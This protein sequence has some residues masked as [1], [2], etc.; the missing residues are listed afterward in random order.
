LRT[1]LSKD[2][3]GENLRRRVIPILQNEEAVRFW[4]EDF[5]SYHPSALDPVLNKL[6]KFLLNDR[7]ARILRQ[8]KNKLDFRRIMDSS[9]IL[10]MH[11]PAGILGSDS[12]NLIG[13]LSLALFYHAAMSRANIP[14][15]ERVPFYLYVDEFHRF[16]TKSTEDLLRETRKYNLGII[17][18]FQQ[19][20]QISESVRIALGNV[21]SLVAFGLSLDDAQRIFKEFCGQVGVERLLQ[22]TVGEAYAMIGNNLTTLTTFPPCQVTGKGFSQQIRNITRERYCIETSAGAKA[23]VASKSAPICAPNK[24]AGE[25]SIY[26]EF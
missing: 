11:L 12:T 17:M 1:L 14:P 15:E 3:E 16:P 6:G 18:A 21:G 25:E 24:K 13:S 4:T 2:R 7:I 5:P 23:D 9:K 22:S 19:R 26:D 8:K 10:L 20:E